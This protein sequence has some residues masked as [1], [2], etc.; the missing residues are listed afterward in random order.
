[1]EFEEGFYVAH[2]L[3]EELFCYVH[4]TQ[5]GIFAKLIN[6][7]ELPV[8]SKP[9]GNLDYILASNLEH[10]HPDD[11]LKEAWDT[12]SFIYQNMGRLETKQE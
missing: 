9:K 4:T 1:M 2:L 7:R 12:I 3:G 5:K 11:H 10:C 8:S 6:G